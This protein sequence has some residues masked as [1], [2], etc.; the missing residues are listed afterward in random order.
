MLAAFFVN[1]SAGAPWLAALGISI[2]NTLEP[3]AAVFLLRRLGFRGL[4]DRFDE[5]MTFVVAAACLSTL[6][7][8]SIGVSSLWLSG[9]ITRSQ[10]AATWMPW[11]LG[12]MLG[13]LVIAPLLL[14]WL[15]KDNPAIASWHLLGKK[16]EALALLLVMTLLALSVFKSSVSQE[17][18]GMRPYIIFPTLFWAAS[19]FGLKGTTLA[20][21]VLAVSSTWGTIFEQ[22]QGNIVFNLYQLQAFLSVFSVTAL[23]VAA[24]FSERATAL[25]KA[26]SAET[27][28][29][30]A[31]KVK[32]EFLAT[33]SHELR[34]PLNVIMGYA[35]LI[36]DGQLNPESTKEAIEAI[37][38]SS[39]SQNQLIGELLDISRIVSGKFELEKK[40]VQLATI[41]QNAVNNV[42]LSAEAKNITLTLRIAPGPI[43]VLGDST[44]LQQILWN[45]CTNAVKFTPSKGRIDI[46]VDHVDDEV[47]I[48][49]S[50]SGQ[51]IDPEFLPYVFRPFYQQDSSVSRQHSGLGLGLAIVRHLVEMHGG[52]VAAKSAGQGQGS[53]FTVRMPAHQPAMSLKFEAHP[54][55]SSLFN[56]LPLRGLKILVVDDEPSTRHLFWRVLKFSGAD[57]SAVGSVAEAMKALEKSIPHAL[58]S[59]IGMPGEDGFSLIEKVRKLERERGVHIPAAALTAYAREDEREHAIEAGYEIHISKPVLPSRLIEAVVALV[60]T[61]SRNQARARGQVKKRSDHNIN[62]GYCG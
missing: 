3:V 41:V 12:D 40:P 16:F 29:R 38:R 28:M 46:V 57:V 36:R 32:D 21:F 52:T 26:E 34:S 53:T 37:Y 61:N 4:F 47:E 39:E 14:V 20:V 8:A 43:C 31:S 49:V 60:G 48:S 44:R 18:I 1:F 13:D 51:G 50:D 58:I 55:I 11:W 7:S 9:V 6:L 62:D 22:S 33:L 30:A 27:E 10:L 5:V 19:R 56:A 2:G 25:I 15:Q 17:I 42:R 45:L 23:A 35:A 59:D 54:S 24:V